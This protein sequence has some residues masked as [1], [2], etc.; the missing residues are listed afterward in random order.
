MFD[1]NIKGRQHAQS[2]GNR[3]SQPILGRTNHYSGSQMGDMGALHPPNQFSTPSPLVQT[4]K[5]KTKSRVYDGNDD[6][7][8]YISQFEII[9]DLNKWDYRTKSFQLAGNLAREARGLLGELSE[10]QRRDYDSIVHGL[11]M[12]FGSTETAEMFRARIE[13]SDQRNK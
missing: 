7:D 5:E 13:G 4:S 11:K 1:R 3:E 9:A 12:R 2:Y 6:F 10:E 8:D